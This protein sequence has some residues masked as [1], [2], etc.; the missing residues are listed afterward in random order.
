MPYTR[1]TNAQRGGRGGRG[2]GGNR[3]G[4]RRNRRHY[5]KNNDKVVEKKKF[6]EKCPFVVG[7]AEWARWRDARSD[8]SPK[9]YVGGPVEPEFLPRIRNVNSKQEKIDDNMADLQ[10]EMMDN[11]WTLREDDEGEFFSHRAYPGKK[12][13]VHNHIALDGRVFKIPLM[14]RC[15]DPQGLGCC[16][17]YMPPQSFYKISSNRYIEYGESRT[18]KRREQYLVYLSHRL[19]KK[20]EFQ[21]EA[22]AIAKA[23]ELKKRQMNKTISTV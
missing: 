15:E 21:K 20:E 1:Q 6:I 12:V 5:N 19:K 4:G 10:Q 8:Y 11:N 18:G 23:M 7:S 3:Q 9:I 13:Q 17:D 16:I 2:R 22:E 14:L